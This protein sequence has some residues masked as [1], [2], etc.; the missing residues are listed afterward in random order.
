MRKFFRLCDE[1]C[2]GPVMNGDN[3]GKYEKTVGPEKGQGLG[4]GRRTNYLGPE[5]PEPCRP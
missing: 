4:P 5:M 3:M 2:V 1:W